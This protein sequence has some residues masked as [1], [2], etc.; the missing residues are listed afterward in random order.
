M[1]LKRI[2]LRN[3]KRFVDFPAQFSPGINVVKGPLNEVGKST[4]LEG[5]I[6]ARFH[7]AG[8]TSKE[9]FY[10]SSYPTALLLRDYTVQI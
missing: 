8:S 2:E 5:I 10:W 4:L 7:N 9:A 1:W 3:F 6:A